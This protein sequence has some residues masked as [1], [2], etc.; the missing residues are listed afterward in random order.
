M[1]GDETIKPFV[2]PIEPLF[3]CDPEKMCQEFMIAQAAEAEVEVVE[4]EV[5]DLGHCQW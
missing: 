2:Y 3:V 4:A 1:W 5:E